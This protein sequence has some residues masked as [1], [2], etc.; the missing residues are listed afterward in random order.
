[1]VTVGHRRLAAAAVALTAAISVAVVTVQDPP[2]DAA[3]ADSS[4]D[5]TVGPLGPISVIGD[6][7]MQG[8]IIFSPTLSDHLVARGWGPVRTRAGVDYRTGSPQTSNGKSQTWATTWIDQ[9]RSIGWNPRDVVVNLGAN[10]SGAC[11][12]NLQCARDA[13]THLVDAI[14]PGHRIWWP[15][16]TRHPVYRH[17]ADNW[18]LALQQ[19]ADEREDLFTWDWDVVMYAEGYVCCDHTHLTVSGYRRRSARMGMEITADLALATRSGGDAALPET[20]GPPSELVPV[21]PIRIIDTREDEPGHL[22][23]RTQIV[24]DVSDE[25]PPGT[26]AIAAYVSATRTGDNGFLTAYECSGGRPHASN[27]NYLRSET[28]GAVAITPIA[29]DGTFC[30]YTHADADVLVDLQAA[31]VPLGTGGLQFSP[32]DTPDRLVDTRE[33]GK[34]QIIEVPVP[35]GAEVAAV[36]VTAIRSELPG[37]LTAYPCTDERPK[38]ATVNHLPGEVISGAAFVPVSP[39]GTICVFSLNPVDLTIDLT[40]VFGD[41]GDLVFLPVRPTRTLD[42]REATGGWGPIHGQRQQID[43]RVAPPEA[44]AVSGTLTIVTPL[45]PGYVRAWGCGAAPP[46]A[47][48]TA[49][50]GGVLANSVTTGVDDEGR[51]CF[52][53]RSATGTLFDTSGWW[54]PP[55]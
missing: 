28:R 4:Y 1:L 39:D 15:K 23:A 37:Y 25:V 13:I 36:S 8:G 16:I 46:T 21:D 45:R 29:P 19:I 31:F 50:A 12:T 3:L 17:Q 22:D 33:T 6:S 54:V 44:E 55:P 10:D 53:S 26:T 43:A 27:A 51:L 2:A 34:Q 41:A 5:P 49:L 48:V 20:T 38:V 35:A 52:Y 9:W 18:N 47:N 42:T 32:L 24:I 11:N 14:G 7:V 30:L 40:G